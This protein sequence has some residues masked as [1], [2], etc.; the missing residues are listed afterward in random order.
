[1]EA[2]V[3]DPRVEGVYVTDVIVDRELDYANIYVS[4]LDGSQRAEEILEGLDN[5]SGFI[6]YSLSQ[7]IDLRIMPKLR[8]H[9]MIRRKKPNAL[10][11]C[12]PKSGEEREARMGDTSP[13]AGSLDEDLNVSELDRKIAQRIANSENILIA[14]HVRPDADAVGSMLGLGIALLNAGKQVQMVLQ[15]GAKGF[16]YLPKADLI[17]NTPSINADMI[18][19]VDCSDPSVLEMCWMLIRLLIWWWTT[20]R[21]T[22]S[23]ENS[24][25]LSPSR[26]RRLRFSMTGYRCGVW[27]LM[28]RSRSACC[29]PLW[30]I[31]SVFE[32]LR[33][34]LRF[35][36]ISGIDGSGS[37]PV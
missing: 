17:V 6:R 13:E 29:L 18:V 9:W 24:T 11:H 16:E 8:F 22:C 23:L 10:R 21:Q 4:S 33:W 20:T 15:D 5:A 19:V 28:R 26:S 25:W 37:Q 36:Q 14:S 1:L 12:W 34:I 32:Q 31:R 35:A 3:N 7:E 2:K 30:G 27:H